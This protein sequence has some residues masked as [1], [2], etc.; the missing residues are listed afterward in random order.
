M[1]GRRN[2]RGSSPSV[3]QQGYQQAAGVLSQAVLSAC[4]ALRAVLLQKLAALVPRLIPAIIADDGAQGQHGVDLLR[5]PA[6]ARPIEPTLDDLL[7]GTLHHA[8]ANG[9]L[10]LLVAR[11]VHLCL[12]FLQI[13]HMFLRLLQVWV[14]VA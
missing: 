7:M 12:A 5:A 14:L 1:N 2:Q 9:P 13:R 8:R 10:L 4:V 6:H 11:I 3:Q